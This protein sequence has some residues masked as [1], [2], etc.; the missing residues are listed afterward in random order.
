MISLPINP[1]EDDL[2]RCHIVRNPDDTMTAC[3]IAKHVVDAK[4]TAELA[5]ALGEP[6]KRKRLCTK[7]LTVVVNAAIEAES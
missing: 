6:R 3:N 2:A 4:S 1:T 5:K 7:C